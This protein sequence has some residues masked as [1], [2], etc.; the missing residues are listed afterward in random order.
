MLQSNAIDTFRSIYAT[1]GSKREKTG[2]SETLCAAFDGCVMTSECYLRAGSVFDSSQ[3]HTTDPVVA[4]VGYLS[5][6]LKYL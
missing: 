2:G 5:A 4:F 3:N 6:P 1:E